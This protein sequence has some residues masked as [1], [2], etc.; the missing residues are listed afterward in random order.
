MEDENK[1][2]KDFTLIHNHVVCSLHFQEEDFENLYIKEL[3]PKEH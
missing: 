2:Y 1:S 3:L